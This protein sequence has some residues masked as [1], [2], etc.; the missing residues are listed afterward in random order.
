MLVP[1]L[2]KADGSPSRMITELTRQEAYHILAG[3]GSNGSPSP[4][5]PRADADIRNAILRRLVRD[6]P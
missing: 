5:L 1:R 6:M 4:F 3:R 2:R